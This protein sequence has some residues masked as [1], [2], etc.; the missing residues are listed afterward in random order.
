MSVGMPARLPL[1]TSAFLIH[2]FRVWGAQ[3]VS[4]LAGYKGWVHADG[5]SGFND[6]FGGDK[7]D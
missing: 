7:A 4:Y 2:S 5:Y 6:L 1:S 3:P